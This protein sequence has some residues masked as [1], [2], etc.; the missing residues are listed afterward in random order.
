MLGV[1]GFVNLFWNKNFRWNMMFL[2]WN[3]GHNKFTNFQV[4]QNG[5]K[6]KR[7]LH[8]FSWGSERFCELFWK[9]KEGKNKTW[10]NFFKNKRET[11]QKKIYFC[12]LHVGWVEIKK[13]T[14]KYRKS[15]KKLKWFFGKRETREKNFYF[16]ILHVCWVGI[17]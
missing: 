11:R 3:V 15:F 4:S 5:C 2:F 6:M 12:I 13:I 17:N 8:I 7:C 9:C 14:V 1:R 16:C 10:K